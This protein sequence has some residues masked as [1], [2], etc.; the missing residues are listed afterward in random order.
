M[1]K[2]IMLCLLASIV[3]VSNACSWNRSRA[4]IPGKVPVHTQMLKANPWVSPPRDAKE[5]EGRLKQLRAQYAPFLR[6]LPD[7][8]EV[9]KQQ[10]LD[11]Q[12]RSKFELDF[13]KD[14]TLERP[15]A[16]AWYAPEF[17]DS[18][19]ETVTV[20]EW[21]WSNFKPDRKEFPQPSYPDSVILW[22]RKTFDAPRP[23]PGQRV[24]LSFA[25][26]DWEAQVW[27]N[28]KELG[29]HVGYAEPFRFDVTDLLRERNCLAVRVFEGPGFG[30]PIAQWSILPHSPANRGP[31]QRF[32]FRDR[33][34]SIPGFQYGTSSSGASGFGIHREVCL[35]TTAQTC[36]GEVF[37]RG[38]PETGEAKV[39]IETDSLAD[40]SLA[41]EVQIMPENFKGRQYRVKKT[42]AIPRGPGRVEVAIPMPNAR[43]WWPAEPCLYR[44]RVTLHDGS[45]LA[46]A[47]DAL[48]GC[49]SVKLVSSPKGDGPLADG[50][51]LLNGQ[52]IF[53]RGTSVGPA[54]DLAW[55][56]GETE[57]LTDIV[58]LLK[59]ANFNTVRNNQHVAFDGVREVYDRLGI[60]SQQEQGSGYVSPE[61]RLSPDR[62]AK[63]CAP[64]ARVCY[65]NPGVIL[66]SFMN[67]AHCNMTEPVA[68]I[69]AQDP[70]RLM[71][72]ISG[73][74]FALSEPRY[75]DQLLGSFHNYDVWYG[76]L[77]KLW[78]VGD[79]ILPDPARSRAVFNDFN[80]NPPRDFF[81]V[82][83][84]WRMNL[85]GEYGVEALD[86]YET[87]LNHYPPHWGKTPGIGEDKLWGGAPGRQRRRH[88]PGLRPS[89]PDAEEPRRLHRG[90]PGLPGRRPRRADQ[91]LPP[92]QADDCRLLPVPLYRR[93]PRAV[94]QG[95]R[96]PRPGPQEGLFRDGP[97]QPADRSPLPTA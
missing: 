48:F 94:A 78:E 25:G 47:R 19:W 10:S 95:H 35:E 2:S 17:D 60:L 18:A 40:R 41:L 58:L 67:E 44:C 15:P 11:G 16:P 56:W 57:K 26:V 8:L 12:W 33:A 52:P 70:D 29:T 1:R 23:A 91:G 7:K 20:P 45:R 76:G 6:S 34:N 38:Y 21:R 86:C 39:M 74:L 75:G 36:I 43:L 32:V 83:R 64:L 28:G 62:L 72:P 97:G 71:T 53:L 37:A 89:R 14:T 22:Y 5:L 90:Q 31:N 51:V 84:P 82:M 79:P 46:D 61:H 96:Q 66:L 92:L 3:I 24:F 50:Q 4:D 68:A 77:H 69:L 54:A 27:L 42:V 30:E 13:T 9:R 87:M 63:A 85:V 65:N 81:P 88:S 93:D 73:A 49:R 55:Y 59:A 80:P